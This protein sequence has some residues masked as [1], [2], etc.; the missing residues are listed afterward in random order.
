MKLL[1]FSAIV[2]F[3]IISLTSFVVCEDNDATRAS[4][5]DD[6]K[7]TRREDTDDSSDSKESSDTSS[8]STSSQSSS[9]QFIPQP[10]PVNMFSMPY[11]SSP[12]MATPYP[13]YHA[14]S[15]PYAATTSY[16]AYYRPI[17]PPI[18]APMSPMPP[19]SPGLS[20]SPA[21]LPGPPR[22][23]MMPSFSF[24]HPPHISPAQPTLMPIMMP[25]KRLDD[26][27][28]AHGP[29]GIPQS[30]LESLF[31]SESGL[32]SFSQMSSG[33]PMLDNEPIEIEEAELLEAAARKSAANRRE[34]YEDDNDSYDSRE[35]VSSSRQRNHAPRSRSY[36]SP[37]YYDNEHQSESSGHTRF[38]ADPYEPIQMENRYRSTDDRQPASRRESTSNYARDS[39]SPSENRQYI[40]RDSY[41]TQS[42]NVRS[43]SP[44]SLDQHH[45]PQAAASTLDNDYDSGRD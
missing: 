41:E 33:F 7:M 14:A 44:S 31:N 17:S 35:Q 25:I 6:K 20:P 9:P 23:A 3:A 28:G 43:S 21:Y 11:Y 15:T 27:F 34:S 2:F 22:P 32:E 36:R 40:P 12:P 4:S 39:Y 45:Y 26:P 18:G 1:F 13:V 38:R 42:S 5:K 10:V 29:H 16:A 8:D 30:L 19:M 37:S 24:A